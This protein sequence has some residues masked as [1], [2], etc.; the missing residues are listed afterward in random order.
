LIYV[1]CHQWHREFRAKLLLAHEAA[2][3]YG[4]AIIGKTAPMRKFLENA[5]PGIIIDMAFTQERGEQFSKYRK[6]GHRIVSFCEES[7]AMPDDPKKSARRF[8]NKAFNE[9]EFAVL[10]GEWH[11][12]IIP[13]WMEG[14]DALPLG[15]PRLEILQPK[16]YR[17]YDE[18]RKE[19]KK[20]YGHY[21]LVNTRTPQYTFDDYKTAHRDEIRKIKKKNEHEEC[22]IT[23]PNSSDVADSFE[24]AKTRLR[25]QALQAER[26]ATE[27]GLNVVYR[28][29]QTVANSVLKSQLKDVG[30]RANVDK[31]FDIAPWLDEAALI[32]HHGCTTSIEAALLGTPAAMV[33]DHGRNE[34][35]L[36]TVEASF[37]PDELLSTRPRWQEK[38]KRRLRLTSP[39]LENKLSEKRDVVAKWFANTDGSCTNDL[40]DEI[41]ARG[42]LESVDKR[43]TLSALS[44]MRRPPYQEPLVYIKTNLNEWFRNKDSASNNRP[45]HSLYARKSSKTISSI[46]N[47]SCEFIPLQDHI[48]MIKK[49]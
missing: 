28:P 22:N 18:E 2:E 25:E 12:K 23:P 46:K 34:V 47:K 27:F 29:K 8:G 40:F 33:T 4:V 9:M 36:P 14:D 21:L 13:G 10:W 11:R 17:L 6:M 15:H 30:V 5:P 42:L 45:F 43:D 44:E 7:S 39:D 41:E 31:R 38:Q 24:K 48:Y 16:W 37:T 1:I 35:A 19:I 3:R 49:C 32:I 20:K 26:F